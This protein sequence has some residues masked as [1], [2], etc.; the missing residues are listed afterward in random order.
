MIK[1]FAPVLAAGAVFLLLLAGSASAAAQNHRP[2]TIA[3]CTASGGHT[4]CYAAGDAKH[5]RSLWLHVSAQPR[6]KVSGTWGVTCTK[7]L[8]WRSRSGRF[9]R[10]STVTRRLRLGYTDPGFCSVYANG[11]LSKAGTSLHLWLTV[12]R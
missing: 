4:G 6:Q 1:K 8:H 7:G 11:Q 3:S 12:G 9:H 5:P 2:R 10:T